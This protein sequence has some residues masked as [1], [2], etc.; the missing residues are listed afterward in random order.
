[1]RA[2]VVR[3]LASRTRGGIGW[4]T[5]TRGGNRF[6]EMGLDERPDLDPDRLE[7]GKHWDFFEVVTDCAHCGATDTPTNIVGL[8][9]ACSLALA[10]G[11]IDQEP[12]DD[13]EEEPEE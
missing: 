2:P 8:C 5:D 11:E 12:Q 7:K 13:E 3:S 10:L 4:N 6:E 1:M 9:G